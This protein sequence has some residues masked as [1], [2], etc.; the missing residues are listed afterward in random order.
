[1][2][3]FFL[4]ILFV[5]AFVSLNA[6]AFDIDFSRRQR[7]PQQAAPVPRGDSSFPSE[8][9]VYHDT[10]LSSQTYV[11]AQEKIDPNRIV[12]AEKDSVSPQ[13]SKNYSDAV[14]DSKIPSKFAG[15]VQKITSPS[16]ADRQELV[17]LNTAK[18]FIPSNL[19]L[20]KGFH[21]T[22]HVVNVNEEKKNV[23]F[24]LDAFQQHHATYFGKIK[25]FELDPNKEGIF[26]FQCPETAALG[27]IV[28]FGDGFKV[29]RHLSSER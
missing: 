3:V 9:T 22:L 24:M 25:T 27:K 10:S 5:S 7:T 17:I 20:R 26:E 18:G 15:I 4:G 29:E 19:R 21:Y 2:K 1:M 23:S 14:N 6:S 28:I 16:V 13:E 8:P 11:P 12:P